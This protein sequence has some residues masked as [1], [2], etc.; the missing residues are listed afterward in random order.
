M[1]SSNIIDNILLILND[2]NSSIQT[3]R[4]TIWLCTNLCS[5]HKVYSHVQPLLGP[6]INLLENDD[7]KITKNSAQ[8]IRHIL[9]DTHS[10]RDALNMDLLNKINHLLKS[11]NKTVAYQGT[12]ILG[13]ISRAGSMSEIDQIFENYEF[14]MSFLELVKSDDVA[15]VKELLWVLYKI[16]S[17]AS[18]LTIRDFATSFNIFE[19]LRNLLTW[20]EP[21][22]SNVLNMIMDHLRSLSSVT[23]L[24]IEE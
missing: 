13:T 18:T 10:I 11:S 1:T 8:A 17:R 15:C 24:E 12:L 16:M 4:V 7:F 3:L 22:I 2:I 5:N 19:I 9:R 20:N 6:L 14:S 23:Y 21:N